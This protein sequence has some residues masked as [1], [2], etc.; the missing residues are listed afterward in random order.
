M[1]IFKKWEGDNTIKWAHNQLN[2]YNKTVL[3]TGL[4]ISSMRKGNAGILFITEK[5]LKKY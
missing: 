3:F 2:N 5:V 1:F 4:I